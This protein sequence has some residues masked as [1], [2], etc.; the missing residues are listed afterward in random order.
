MSYLLDTCVISELVAKQ[1]KES[2]LAWIAAI[3]SEKAYLSVVA[4][5]EIQ[6]GIERLPPCRR[7]EDL[8]AWLTDDLLIRFRG[9][10]LPL[11]TEVMLRWG[12]MISRLEAAGTPMPLLDSLV[13]A[14]ALQR[15]LVLV[16]RNE[17]DF[18]RS[19]VELVNPW[20]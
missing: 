9:R 1:P 19:G 14:T 7:K 2:V 18:E 4:L 5:G 3:E 13:A 8:R 20:K 10:I 16:T 12:T 17:E 15:G 11:D 6:K